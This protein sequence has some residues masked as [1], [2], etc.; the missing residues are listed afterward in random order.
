MVFLLVLA[1]GAASG[2]EQAIGKQVGRPTQSKPDPNGKPVFK[3][4]ADKN[5]V[6]LKKCDP[7]VL[8]DTMPGDAFYENGLGIVRS[9]SWLG[10]NEDEDTAAGVLVAVDHDVLLD[11]I[12]LP[13]RFYG[14]VNELDVYLVNTEQIPASD[15]NC[16]RTSPTELCER[17]NDRSV[18]EHWRLVDQAPAFAAVVNVP[19]VMHPQLTSGVRYWVYISVPAPDSAVGWYVRNQNYPGPHFGWSQ[20]NSAIGFQWRTAPEGGMAIRVTALH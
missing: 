7:F 15:T 16:D 6:K 5:Q 10:L 4:C 19:S 14:G 2:A 17:P 13:L 9:P 1:F 12:E 8:Y 11:S 20:R 3:S 18:I